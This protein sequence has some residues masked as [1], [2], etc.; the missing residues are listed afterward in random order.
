MIFWSWED[1]TRGRRRSLSRHRGW[2]TSPWGR[3]SLWAQTQS[4]WQISPCRDDKKNQINGYIKMLYNLLV[5]YIERYGT[6]YIPLSRL[7][8]CNKSHTVPSNLYYTVGKGSSWYKTHN[9]SM[10]NPCVLAIYMATRPRACIFHKHS[11]S[12]YIYYIHGLHDFLSWID[13]HF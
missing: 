9:Y 2:R 4:C 11:V 6:V 3:G 12:C 7:Q 10:R 1:R 13:Y 8:A 5:G